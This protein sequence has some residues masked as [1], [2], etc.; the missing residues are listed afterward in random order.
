VAFL[1]RTLLLILSSAM[2]LFSQRRVQ[3]EMEGIKPM[4]NQPDQQGP[5]DQRTWRVSLMASLQKRWLSIM[6][7]AQPAFHRWRP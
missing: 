2:M 5:A 1:K 6:C 7:P 3:A 4:L